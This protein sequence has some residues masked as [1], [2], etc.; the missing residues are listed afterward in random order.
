MFVYSIY[1]NKAAGECALVYVSIGRHLRKTTLHYGRHYSHVGRCLFT[2]VQL[3]FL[4]GAGQ[5][6]EK[7][8]SVHYLYLRD[9]SPTPIPRIPIPCFS[10]P[11]RPTDSLFGIHLVGDR[12][13]GVATQAES[14]IQAFLP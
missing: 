8:Y 11:G 6:P 12:K 10:L 13:L 1:L 7:L 3:S 5:P 14:E 4:G 9:F 2:K